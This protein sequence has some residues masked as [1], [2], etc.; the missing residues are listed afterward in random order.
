MQPSRAQLRELDHQNALH[1]EH[2]V[3]V[4]RADWPDMRNSPYRTGSVPIGV[5]RSRAF[6]VVAWLEPNGFTRLSVQR[7]EWDK[8]Q[9]R[10]RDDI[11]WDDLQR[12]KREAGFAGMCALEVYPPDHHVVNVANMRHLFL[13]PTPPRFMWKRAV[14]EAEAA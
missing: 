3:V 7:T 14:S 1:P 8:R 4:D 6:L 10:F 11:S 13:M 12:L 2:L 5:Y 9:K